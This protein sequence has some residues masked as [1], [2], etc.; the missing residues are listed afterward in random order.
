METFTNTLL[1]KLDFS[2]SNVFFK[3]FSIQLKEDVIS[4]PNFTFKKGDHFIQYEDIED[5]DVDQNKYYLS[6]GKNVFVFR[7]KFLVSKANISGI[8]VFI[9]KKEM[10]TIFG[11]DDGTQVTNCILWTNNYKRNEGAEIS[12]YLSDNKVGVGSSLTVLGQLES[13]NGQ[14]QLNIRKLKIIDDS[15][16]ELHQFY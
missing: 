8:V 12:K 9:I 6:K 10:R 14:I 15:R 4:I 5:H 16:E 7:D 2:I 1:S 3:F 13:F 11:L